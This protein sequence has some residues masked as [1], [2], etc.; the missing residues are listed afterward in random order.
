M[1]E[2]TFQYPLSFSWDGRY[3]AGRS[4]MSALTRASP[5]F[6]PSSRKEKNRPAHLR[7]FPPSSPTPVRGNVE[8]PPPLPLEY[9]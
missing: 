8:L 5:F 2:F 6:S 7:P 4:K 9:R 3:V 1:S